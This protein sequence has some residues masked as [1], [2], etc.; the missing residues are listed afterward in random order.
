ML[1]HSNWQLQQDLLHT[2]LSMVS[3]TD[4]SNAHL[5]LGSD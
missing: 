4:C 1:Q 3:D 2:A 5:L